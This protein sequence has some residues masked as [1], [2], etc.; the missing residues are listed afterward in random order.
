MN[1]FMEIVKVNSALL[2]NC[3]VLNILNDVKTKDNKKDLEPNARTIVYETSQ[4]LNQFVISKQNTKV[5]S[6][7]VKAVS[8]FGLTEAEKLQL[9]NLRPT[10]PVEVQLIVEESEE[11]LTEEQVESL[12]EII[13][14]ILPGPEEESSNS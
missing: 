10:T 11:R 12:I 13:E 4:Y 9:I 2:S 3:E 7:F 5:I 6:E 1:C 8:K 14:R